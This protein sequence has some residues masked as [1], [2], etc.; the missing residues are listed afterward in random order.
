MSQFGGKRFIFCVSPGRSGSAYLAKLLGSCHDVVAEHEADPVG[1]GSA[2]QQFL[3]GNEA[4]MRRVASRKVAKLRHASACRRA[5][6]ETNHCFIKGFGWFLP[7]MM[8]QESF[9][10]V[11][12]RRDEENVL[13]SLTRVG[14]TPLTVRGRRWMMTPEKA[15]P[16]LPPPRFLLSPQWDYRLL[17]WLRAVMNFVLRRFGVRLWEFLRKRYLARYELACTR[18][19]IRETYAEAERFLRTFPGVQSFEVDLAELND[20]ARVQA[21]LANLGLQAGPETA[22]IVGVSRNTKEGKIC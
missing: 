22:T 3:R 18:W 19:Y 7:N 15:N 16:C 1:N 8:G 21:L 9:V 14:C 4:A 2:M 6:V 13:S 12:L 10:L 17:W 11:T 5:Y 20:D